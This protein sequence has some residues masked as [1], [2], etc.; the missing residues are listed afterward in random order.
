MEDSRAHVYLGTIHLLWDSFIFKIAQQCSLSVWPHLTFFL[1]SG[2]LNLDPY[3]CATITLDPLSH[4]LTLL[5]H[6]YL[7]LQCKSVNVEGPY[8]KI[9]SY[10]KIQKLHNICGL[11]SISEQWF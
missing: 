9:D 5:G 7:V 6:F 3:V 8:K 2:D 1:G 11:Y 4:P 10:M